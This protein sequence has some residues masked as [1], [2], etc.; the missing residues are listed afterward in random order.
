MTTNPLFLL[1]FLPFLGALFALITPSKKNPNSLLQLGILFSLLELICA[2][3]LYLRFEGMSAQAEFSS[4]IPWFSLGAIPIQISLGV[5]G[6]SISLIALTALLMPLVFLQALGSI[7]ERQKEFV[8]WALL[9]ESGMVGV[10]AATDL[11]LFYV[12]WEI[13][14]IPL[15]FLIGIWGGPRK[16]YATIKFF[17]YTLAGSLLMLVGV[18]LL[19]RETAT[20]DIPTLC[21]MNL[22]PSLQMSCFLLFAAAFAVKVPLFPFHTWLPDAHVEAPTGGSVILAGVLLKMGTYG[23]LRFCLPIFPQASE[24]ASPFLFALGAFGVIYGAFLAWA[25]QD[26]KKLVAYSSVSHMGL[27]MLGLFALKPIAVQ[28]AVIQMINHGLSTGALFLLVG[29]IYERRHTRDIAEFGGIAQVM[30]K[31]A[32]L[33]G[34]VAFSSIGL[35]GLNG[36]IGEFLILIGSFSKHPWMTT[37]AGLGVVFGAVYMLSALRRVLFGPLNKES[38]RSLSDLSLREIV[39]VAPI[40][41]L[42]VWIGVA[43]KPFLSKSEAAVSAILQ[44]FEEKK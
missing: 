27:I 17:L 16:L 21:N 36:F 40:L 41:I 18:I 8:F 13:T 30:P 31:F 44:R 23:F 38:N 1:I 32:F 34:I 3:F 33:L 11:V 43:P 4:S 42:I 10:F 5:D 39:L 28:G 25:Q 2:A 6:I 29:M 26:L 24:A 12:F 7:K 22:N 15:Y 9:M 14:L 35:P 37:F 19:L 20:A